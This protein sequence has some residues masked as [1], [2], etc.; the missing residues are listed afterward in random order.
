MLAGRCLT[1]LVCSGAAA[2]LALAA[3]GAERDDITNLHFSHLGIE[4]GLSSGA[5]ADILQDRSGFI[6]LATQDGVNRYDGSRVRVYR[7]RSGDDSTLIGNNS[8]VLHEDPEGYLWV[9]S[10]DR[11]LSRIDPRTGRVRRFG[12]AEGLESLAVRDLASD[13]RSLWVATRGGLHRVDFATLELTH[14]PVAGVD[15]INALAIDASGQLWLGTEGAGVQ[16]R[17]PDGTVNQVVAWQ[18]LRAPVTAMVLDAPR[19]NVWIGTR[20]GGLV[21]VNLLRQNLARINRRKGLSHDHVS[22]LLRLEDHLWVASWGGGLQRVTMEDGAVST[23]P[24]APGSPGAL[25][26]HTLSALY[27]D[28]GGVLWV[29][30]WGRGVNLHHRYGPRFETFRHGADRLDSLSPSSVNF[31]LPRGPNELLVGTWGSGL[32]VVDRST[33]VVSHYP[34]RIDDPASPHD[35]RF[36]AALPLDADTYWIGTDDGLALLDARTMSFQRLSLGDDQPL[37]GHRVRVLLR[38]REGQ[39]WIGTES[40]GVKRYDPAS[41]KLRSYRH[42]LGDPASLSHDQ[43]MALHQDRDGDLW[44]G[45]FGGVNRYLPAE[46]GFAHYRAGA[47]DQGGLS[48][49]SILAFHEDDDGLLWIGTQYGL[50]RLNPDTG[51]TSHYLSGGG[52][53]PNDVIYGILPDEESRLWLSTN[54]GLARFDPETGRSVDYHRSDGLQAEEFNPGAAFRAESGE[55]FFG[56]T[57]GFTSLKPGLI[58]DNPHPPQVQIVD[59]QVVNREAA[60]SGFEPLSP[61]TGSEPYTLS[62]IALGWQDVM[63]QFQL[64][65]LHFSDPAGNRIAYRLLGLDDEWLEL[66]GERAAATFSNLRAGSYTFEVRAANSDGVWE[67]EPRTLSVQVSPPPWRTPWAYF[68]YT[69][70]AVLIALLAYWH[71]RRQLEKEREINEQLRV[72]DER[73]TRANASLEA[74]VRGR[75]QALSQ[76]NKALEELSLTDALTGIRN[77]RFFTERVV[78]QAAAMVEGRL[79]G[80]RRKEDSEH[81]IAFMIDIDKFKRLNDAYGHAVGDDI[82]TEFAILLEDQFRQ[83]DHV[84]RWGGEE[85]LVI[86]CLKK[87]VDPRRVAERIRAAICNHDFCRDRGALTLTCSI[88]FAR[89]PFL[90]DAPEALSIYDTVELA[91]QCLYLAKTTGRNR[92]CGV[93]AGSGLDVDALRAALKEPENVALALDNLVHI[94]MDDAHAT[95]AQAVA[96]AD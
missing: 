3:Y 50:N 53:L 31:V 42:R 34:P 71:F 80:G 67:E 88:G 43:V 60:G 81:V 72:A 12:A 73:L 30:T 40:R 49:D 5:V 45:T 44:V 22:D 75:T 79:A 48:S 61:A 63:V 7:H 94:A 83:H 66:E 27:H 39:V 96:A 15:A 37:A 74:Q 23:V 95:Q 46:D 52:H 11:G 2:L 38:D 9:G 78:P 86:T 16:R 62:Q 1:K 4:Q 14:V 55:L 25:N 29:G 89:F 82:I 26:H 76:A 58:L 8:R 33:G 19:S 35:G 68:G 57:E 92:W 13:P 28:R 70:L 17:D 84:I 20:G 18:E 54:R 85:F 21:R 69:C 65:A 64:A 90:A 47:A 41:G 24:F 32:D 77:R 93:E 36:Y 10:L 56:G 87:K 91:D 6:W 51:E 59:V